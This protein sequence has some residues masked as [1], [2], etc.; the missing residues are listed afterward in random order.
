MTTSDTGIKTN[1]LFFTKG[2]PTQSIWCYE[3][4]Y[5]AGAR[6][7]N[8]TKPI[9]IKEF[10]TE[11]AWWGSEADGFAARVE[12]RCAWKVGIEQIKAANFNPDQKN[13][14]DADTVSHDP[15]ELLRKHAR[16]QQEAQGLRDQ[17]KA[18]LAQSLGGRA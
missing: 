16:L 11:K 13:P 3:H 5:P 6:S 4:P 10:D 7:Y 12:N 15:D 1:L 2:Q 8:K 18:I 14:H 9:R 17:L